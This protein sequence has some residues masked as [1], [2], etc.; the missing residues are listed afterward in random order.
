MPNYFRLQQVLCRELTGWYGRWELRGKGYSRWVDHRR[1]LWVTS[2]SLKGESSGQGNSKCKDPDEG[3]SLLFYRNRKKPT[4]LGESEWSRVTKLRSWDS[5]PRT[6]ESPWRIL[7]G[8]LTWFVFFS[9]KLFW[10][11]CGEQSGVKQEW[12]QKTSKETTASSQAERTAAWAR[13]ATTEMERSGRI[14]V[15]F[16]ILN[17][18]DCLVTWKW[19]TSEREES[20]MTPSLELTYTC[21]YV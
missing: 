20:R 11:L 10:L 1:F 12:R 8:L 9:S 13:A 6:K 19:M 3:E 16:W 17:Q 2:R 15:M 7:G 14:L 21:Y 18:P 5:I 4:W